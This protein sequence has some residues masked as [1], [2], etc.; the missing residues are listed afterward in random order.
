MYGNARGRG[1]YYKRFNRPEI[2]ANY[3]LDSGFHK[4]IPAWNNFG[5]SCILT[6]WGVDA[7][8]DPNSSH[9]EE[10]IWFPNA[11]RNLY[12]QIKISSVVTL[13]EGRTVWNSST[14]QFEVLSYVQPMVVGEPMLFYMK[15]YNHMRNLSKTIKEA[16]RGNVFLQQ[17]VSAVLLYPL[18]SQNDGGIRRAFF[19]KPYGIDYADFK[20]DYTMDNKKIIAEIE[21]PNSKQTDLVDVTSL[22]FANA[23]NR[24]M[25]PIHNIKYNSG[26]NISAYGIP[27]RIRFYVEDNTSGVRSELSTSAIKVVKRRINS[28][29]CFMIEKV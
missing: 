16:M 6:Q 8:L 13:M 11:R 7:T 19:M 15:S 25:I 18:Y 1:G 4:M 29:V 21:Y 17:S 9:N 3:G 26:S 12:N 23:R 27:S 22:T 2:Q 24:L 28:S 20:L 14:R 10:I 5:L